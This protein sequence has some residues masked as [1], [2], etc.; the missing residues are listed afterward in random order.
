MEVLLK[1]LLDVSFLAAEGLVLFMAVAITVIALYW[2]L[3]R[4]VNRNKVP[5]SFYE[6]RCDV[7]SQ[8]HRLNGNE[9]KNTFYKKPAFE[10]KR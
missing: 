10:V 4:S 2:R 6:K 1:P 3:T 8:R 9:K 5:V 7:L